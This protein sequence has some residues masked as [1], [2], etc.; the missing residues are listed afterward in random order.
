MSS[1]SESN[2]PPLGLGVASVVL[3]VISTLL[4][5]LPIL[6]TPIA[7]IGLAL[8]VVGCAAWDG[9]EPNES[10]LVVRGT[11]R[12]GTRPDNQSGDCLCAERIRGDA[13]RPSKRARPRSAVRTAS[14]TSVGLTDAQ[15]A[16]ASRASVCW[17][18]LR[19][20]YLPD[21]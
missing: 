15:T 17:P 18:T 21:C 1:R 9:V 4:F 14:G 10:A 11:G 2:A 16:Q 7:L 13:H 20:C 8:A 5:F 6:A 19:R 3:G 12:L